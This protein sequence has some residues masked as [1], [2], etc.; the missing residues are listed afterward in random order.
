METII[1]QYNPSIKDELMKFLDS[2]SKNDLEIIDKKNKE[3][4]AI[5]RELYQDYTISKSPNANFFSLEEVDKM[6]DAKI[7]SF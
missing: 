5:K 1:L 6:L 3:F 2:F 7:D 4:E